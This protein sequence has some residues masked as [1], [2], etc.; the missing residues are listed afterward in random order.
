MTTPVI[1]LSLEAPPVE[2]VRPPSLTEDTVLLPIPPKKPVP[3]TVI[4]KGTRFESV[5]ALRLFT[6][7]AG[8]VTVN[9]SP[10][11][12]AV[13]PPSAATVIS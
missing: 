4:V 5:L 1:A 13:V 2:S 7:G 3:D 11:T 10:D 9:L 8:V 12:I 6:V